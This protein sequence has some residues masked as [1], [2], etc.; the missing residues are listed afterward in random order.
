MSA[1]PEKTAE[2]LSRDE[3]RSAIFAA[4]PTHYNAKFN[5]VAVILV[6]PSLADIMSAQQ[7]ED[8][9][10]AAAMMLV[11]FV[12]LPNGEPLFE[13]GD[14]EQI[15]LMPFNQDMRE[16]N[17]QIQKLIGVTPE[18]DDKSPPAPAAE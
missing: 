3:A 12:H 14:V 16:L 5:G 4:K 10:R 9:K 17:M 2:T 1:Q 8:R 7:E 15:L 11:R 6:E 18:A 13:E